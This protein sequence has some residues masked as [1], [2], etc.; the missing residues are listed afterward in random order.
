MIGVPLVV[1]DIPRAF[2]APSR[3]GDLTDGLDGWLP[4]PYSAGAWTVD[5][6]GLVHPTTP[7]TDTGGRQSVG[8]RATSDNLVATNGDAT[9]GSRLTIVGYTPVPGNIYACASQ[10]HTPTQANPSL[11][12]RTTPTPVAAGPFNITMSMPNVSAG[13]WEYVG[14]AFLFTPTV[15][16]PYPDLSTFTVSQLT[17]ESSF[18]TTDITCLVDRVS[19]QHGRDDDTNQPDASSATVDLSY[20]SAT[21]LDAPDLMDA[22]E[23]GAP[24]A[25][26]VTLNGSTYRR[27][28]GNITDVAIGWDDAGAQTPERVSAQL[29]A[30]SLLGAMGRAVIGDTPW[31]QELDGARAAHIFTKAEQGLAGTAFTI[32]WEADP[33]TITIYARDVDSQPALDLLHSVAESAEAI[34]WQRLD[35][36]ICYADANRRNAGA[37]VSLVL[38]A[39]DLLV[40][41]TWKRDLSGL[42]NKVTIGYGIPDEEGDQN[43]YTAYDSTSRGRYGPYDYS[44]STELA[45]YADAVDVAQDVLARQ[46]TPAWNLTALPVDVAGLDAARTEQLLALDMHA[47]VQLTGLPDSSPTPASARLWLEGWAETL[48]PGAHDITLA[49]SDYARS[50][51]SATWD[52]WGPSTWNETP[53]S[54]RWNDAR[55]P[56]TDT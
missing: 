48:E 25:V 44:V 47:L 23:I 29:V 12:V 16:S 18:P 53:S 28:T 42:V 45:A 54:L 30:V 38:D 2:T 46:S 40:T 51:G 20:D 36:T 55:I 56:P 34:L 27:F 41:P 15:V 32:D 17:M 3:N 43:R 33:G 37:A 52:L 50:L 5:A 8:L 14:P 13:A 21:D 4:A 7:G 22:L 11:S 10:A 9:S 26:S 1:A 39:C 31:P 6:D 24:L 49:V 35:G 19:I